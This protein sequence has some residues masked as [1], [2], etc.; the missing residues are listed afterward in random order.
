MPPLPDLGPLDPPS[1]PPREPRSVT[2]PEFESPAVVEAA[3][4]VIE[5]QGDR[6][7]AP[8]TSTPLPPAPRPLR[9][10]ETA[11]GVVNVVTGTCKA[12]GALVTGVL[13][14]L[15]TY[16]ATAP[17]PPPVVAPPEVTCP[18]WT[19]EEAKRGPLCQRV[20]ELEKG[21]NSVS[22]GLGTTKTAVGDLQRETKALGERVPAV[23]G[24]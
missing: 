14:A 15:A 9:W 1:E 5:G 6:M 20:H 16:R 12:V 18:H 10:Y 21:L 8:P 19:D 22:A 24:K 2:P 3:R 11:E 7:V 17:A 4:K 13:V 23:V